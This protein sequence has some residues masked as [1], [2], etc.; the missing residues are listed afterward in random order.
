MRCGRMHAEACRRPGHWSRL[1]ARCRTEAS[2]RAD[3]ICLRCEFANI[4][5]RSELSSRYRRRCAL[6]GIEHRNG[7]FMFGR[8][9]HVPIDRTGMDRG[10]ARSIS[11]HACFGEEIAYN[12]L[13]GKNRAHKLRRSLPARDASSGL[14]LVQIRID[15]VLPQLFRMINSKSSIVIR[16]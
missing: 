8:C 13:D 9:H 6:A 4:H 7:C 5:A 2:K 12:K 15:N 11:Q 14:A 3:T 16:M 1:L 10:Y